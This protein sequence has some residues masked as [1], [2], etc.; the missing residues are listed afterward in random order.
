MEA[1]LIAVGLAIAL[2]GLRAAPRIWDGRAHADLDARTRAFWLWGEGTR[3]GFVRANFV[4]V[5]AA[6]WIGLAGLS[7]LLWKAPEVRALQGP[8]AI[9]LVFGVI[10]LIAFSILLV[11]ITL[12]NRPRMVVPPALRGELGMLP[13]WLAKR[14]ARKAKARPPH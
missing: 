13:E 12:F 10:V 9:L 3:R 7:A 6:P 4:T 2:L 11:T 1:V 14:R 8:L 5:L